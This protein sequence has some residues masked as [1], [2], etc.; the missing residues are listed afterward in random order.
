MGIHHVSPN[1]VEDA[2]DFL[3]RQKKI[4]ETV[5]TVLNKKHEELVEKV[6]QGRHERKPFS[7]GDRVFEILVWDLNRSL[8]TG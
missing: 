8:S 5:G 4:D 2:V 6:N 1:N 3:Q 7:K